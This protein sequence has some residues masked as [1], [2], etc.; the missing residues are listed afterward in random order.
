MC[1]V[2]S[3][4][5]DEK[6]CIGDDVVVT[7]VEIKGNAVRLAIDAP[8]DVQIMRRELLPKGADDGSDDD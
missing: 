3:R 6:I 1:L 8:R 5:K 7:V 2:L 4:K